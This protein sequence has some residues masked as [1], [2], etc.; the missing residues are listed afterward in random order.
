MGTTTQTTNSQSS[1]T[2]WK[3]QAAALTDAFQKAQSA[4]TTSSQAQAPTDFVAQFTP[5]QLA[6]FRSMLGYANGNTSP[7]TTSATGTALQ[8][9]GTNATQGALS[10]LSNFDPTK[11]NNTQSIIDAAKQYA[12]GQDIDAQT[13]KATQQARETVRDITLPGISQNAAISGN[14]NS[15]RTGVA[16][17]LVNRALAENVA[18]TRNSLYSNA[19]ANGLNLASSN[20]NANNA[21]TLGALSSAAGQ[22]TNAENSGVNASSA[23]INDQTN[24]FSL[25]NAAGTGEQNANQA[26]L[27]NQQAQYQ[28]LVSSP[29]ASLQQLMSIIGSQ[30][31]GQDTTGTATQSTTPSAMSVIGGLL[32]GVGSLAGTAGGLGWRPFG[33]SQ[34]VFTTGAAGNYVYPQFR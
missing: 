32:G 12:D 2:P 10:G 5:D 24:L 7:A 20:A 9:A 18:D 29:Y 14:T 34:P 22:G 25:A 4:Y 1:S 15:S 28:S 23:G 16:E 3:P 33:S 17:G 30:K 19:F 11:L 21:S 26:D 6:T 31:W 13:R 8:T 27:N